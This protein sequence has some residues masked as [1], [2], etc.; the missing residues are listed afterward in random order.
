MKSC[1]EIK[2]TAKGVLKA[3]YWVSVF[4]VIVLL[5]MGAVSLSSY[6]LLGESVVK[7]KVS[8]KI[9]EMPLLDDLDE[10]GK[11]FVIGFATVM[12]I[13]LL[14]V[15]VFLHVYIELPL[16]VGGSRY[17]LNAAKGEGEA[18]DVLSA[19]S[20]G[21]Y[22]NIVS[23]MFLKSLRL[24]LWSLLFFFPVIY[25]YYQ[26]RMV[27]YI[28]AEN[29]NLTPQEAILLS[30]GMME[31]KKWKCFLLD[32]SFIGWDILAVLTCGIV[33]IFYL[34]PLKMHALAD[35]YEEVK[36]DSPKARE[37]LATR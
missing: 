30:K 10:D 26:F 15:L 23:G 13:L 27:E 21:K 32:L 24:F 35:F 8:E 29:P 34:M 9:D 25:K 22:T 7:D 12:L 16:L 37:I 5:A 19:F 20:K 11:A 31:G 33:A 6:N 3:N 4:I 14:T 1:K 2:R 28:L 18:G 17:A 36:K